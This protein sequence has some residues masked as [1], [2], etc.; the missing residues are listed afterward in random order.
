MILNYYTLNKICFLFYILIYIMLN[1]NNKR[2]VWQKWEEL[3]LQ[4]YVDKWYEILDTN[5]TIKWWE[6]DIIAQKDWNVVFVEVKVVNWVDEIMWYITPKK[7]KNL[8][9]TIQVY[10]YRKNLKFFIRLDVVFIKNN[11]ILEVFENVTNR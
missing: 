4:Y 9:H 3:A 5:Y 7:L 2:Q 1:T 8:E 6:L 10:L 11:Q